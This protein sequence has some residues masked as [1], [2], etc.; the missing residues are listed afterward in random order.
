[1]E[2]SERRSTAVQPTRT[3]AINEWNGLQ[4]RLGQLL[5]VW[6]RPSLFEDGFPRT[7]IEETDDSYIIELDLPGV[8]KSDIN[9]E[10]AGRRLI[11]SGVRKEKERVGVLRHRSRPVGEFRHEIVLPGKIDANRVTAKFGDG[12]LTVEVAKPSAEKP[13]RIRIQ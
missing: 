5:E 6:P 13:R 8:E 4:N 10:M 9:T 12:V 11:V 3:D 7:D 1:M 2:S